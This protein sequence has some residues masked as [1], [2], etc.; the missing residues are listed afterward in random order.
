MKKREKKDSEPQGRGG[1]GDFHIKRRE[2]LVVPFRG[3]KKRFWLL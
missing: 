3:Y 1:G 2:V